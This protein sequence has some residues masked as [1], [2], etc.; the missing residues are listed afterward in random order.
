MGPVLIALV[1]CCLGGCQT[2]S[3]SR[4]VRNPFRSTETEPVVA[5]APVKREQEIIDLRPEE[6]IASVYDNGTPDR[7]AA[8]SRPAP[9]SSQRQTAR[10][11]ETLSSP[12][13]GT[14]RQLAG[15]EPQQ[16]QVDPFTDLN[17]NPE[18]DPVIGP[19]LSQDREFQ[20]T[21]PRSSGAAKLKTEQ[22][23]TAPLPLGS[24][25]TPA[26]PAAPAPRRGSAYKYYDVP[27]TPSAPDNINLHRSGD[28]LTLVARE[29]PLNAVLQM[30]AQQHGLNLVL[31]DDVQEKV[32]VTL[33]DVPLDDALDTILA[34]SNCTWVQQRNIIIVSR[35]SKESLS[36]PQMQG[37]QVRVITLNFVSAE[38][39]EKVVTGLLSPVGKIFS[40]QTS[41]M[42]GRRSREQIIVEDL[43]E[44]LMRIED[45]VART[46]VAPRQVL[47]EAHILQVNLDDENR[48][49]VNLSYVTSL[50]GAQFSIDSQGFANPAGSPAMVLNIDGSKL[51]NVIEIIKDTTDAKTLASP[52]VLV[53]NG[54]EA[55]IQ[56]GSQLG[57]IVT[58]T[59][60]TS[61]LQNVDFM[62]VGVVLNVTPHIS[63][64]GQILMKVKPE[65]ST[66]TVNAATGV[67]DKDTTE[68]DTTVMLPDGQGIVLGGLI[69]EVDSDR[70][71]K[72]PY[73]GDI[74]YVGRMFGRR[75][76]VRERREIII[77]LVPRIVPYD[78]PYRC[79]DQDQFYRATTPLLEGPLIPVPRPEPVLLDAMENPRRIRRR[80]LGPPVVTEPYCPPGEAS[81]AP[82]AMPPIS[83]SQPYSYEQ[84]EPYE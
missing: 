34:A 72:I 10:T 54:Q 17:W 28:F 31:S 45:Y 25:P 6:Y 11:A 77:T 67:P 44:Y 83:N 50:A 48:H 16:E 15:E 12:V 79:I 74:K 2:D 60:E 70:Q 5:E 1:V 75:T 78:D 14:I 52:K 80:N 29:A 19:E 81:I 62:D 8:A 73:I 38:E 55:K 9:V 4:M 27:L 35:I 24:A 59:T 36:G 51:D 84:Y 53:L 30:I 26:A 22:W 40:H 41:P 13:P 3:L 39:V 46:D 68:V 49:G 71:T 66:G 76:A 18:L 65:V 82:H 42:D 69:Q 21:E 20:V 23:E 58:T 7:L 63:N 33:N 64:N 32:T 43:P 47:I 57:Y 61:T 56:I 37:R